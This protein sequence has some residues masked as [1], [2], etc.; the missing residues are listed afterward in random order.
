VAP[1]EWLTGVTL[2]L[3]PSTA[4]RDTY[5]FEFASYRDGVSVN[6]ARYVL[7][8]RAY[9]WIFLAPWG[10]LEESPTHYGQGEQLDHFELSLRRFLAGRSP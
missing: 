6:R 10:D 7:W 3:I 9:S 4:E 5:V 2:G 8:S 1:Q